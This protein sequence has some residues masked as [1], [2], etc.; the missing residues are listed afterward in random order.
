MTRPKSQNNDRNAGRK[1]YPP[2]KPKRKTRNYFLTDEEEQAV[3]VFSVIAKEKG[4]EHA[5]DL[6]EKIKK[7]RAE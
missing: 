5:L 6:L 2:D 4:M 3:R 1:P 7:L